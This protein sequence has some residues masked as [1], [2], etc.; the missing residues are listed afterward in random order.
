M[1][2]ADLVLEH[3]Y[4]EAKDIFLKLLE[5]WP[6]DVEIMTLHANIYYFE[7]KLIEAEN[8]LNQVLILD[9]NYPMALYFLGVIHHEKAEYKKAI[10]MYETA[11]KH[12]SEKQKKDIADVYQNMGCSLWEIKRR[13][14]ALEAWKTCLKYNPRQ[15]YARE[16]LRISTNEYGMPKVPCFDDYYAFIDI[17]NKEYLV[18]KGKESFDDIEEHRL[19]LQKTMTAWNDKIVSKYGAKLDRIK[20]KD[21]IKLFKET[22]VS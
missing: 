5:M 1:Y 10:H 7:G 3:K 22:K 20:T 18:S 16:N 11:L 19:V 2:A 17:Q 13:E 4:D 15:K 12:Y 21:K 8:R 14:E 9:P 6:N